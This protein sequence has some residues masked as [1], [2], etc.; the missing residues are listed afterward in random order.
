VNSLEDIRRALDQS[1][2][3]AATDARG[4]I[5]Y[6]N[7][8]FCEI[9]GYSRDE[10]LGQDHRVVNSG[11]H[12]KAFMRDLWQTIRKGGVWRG[13]I[14]NR[15]KDGSVY[16]VATTIVPF[17]D[18][19]GKP[20]QY[21]AIRNDIT[22]RKR[23]EEEL[24]RMVRKLA[25]VSDT[26]RRRAEELV[27]AREELLSVNRRLVEEQAKLLRAEKLSSLG[28]LASGVAHEINNPLAGVMLCLKALRSGRLSDTRRE[29]YLDAMVDGLERIRAT[30]RSLLDYARVSQQTVGD[31]QLSELFANSLRLL[32]PVLRKKHLRIK[33]QLPAEPL[34]L[35]GDTSQLM[36]AVV[37]VLINAIYVSPK[38]GQI[39]LKGFRLD[40]LVAIEVRDFGPG[41]PMEHVDRVCDPFFTT[42]P[43]GEGTGL[44]LAVT[45]SIVQAHRGDLVF[46]NAADGG[47]R[48]TILLP[49]A[50]GVRD[51]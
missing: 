48:V 17:L 18:E 23:A 40:G 50:E 29:E 2:I 12:S 38:R 31:I 11:Y 43:E 25:E 9:S 36:Q 6:V 13:D 44:G 27:T 4:V 8:R 41:I 14:R 30:V 33:K 34:V 37:N 47:T 19:N 20:V 5:T 46:D 49:A 7:D 28:L 51:A 42:K 24:R 10:L 35:H 32:K 39:E 21:L 16:W 3:V 15:A 26:E 22:E 1:S 45:L